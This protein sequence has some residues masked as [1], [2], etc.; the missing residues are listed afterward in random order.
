LY[1]NIDIDYKRHN[2]NDAIRVARLRRQREA[3]EISV[4]TASRALYAAPSRITAR[5]SPRR[6]ELRAWRVSASAGDARSHLRA[7]RALRAGAA[8]ARGRLD[9]VALSLL[10]RDYGTQR[11]R[12]RPSIIAENW[13]LACVKVT[14]TRQ[15]G[16]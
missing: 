11:E 13:S 16:R 8:V 3:R 15:V 5:L 1:I 9:T 10:R 7:H 12:E 2:A 6:G 14:P 4:K